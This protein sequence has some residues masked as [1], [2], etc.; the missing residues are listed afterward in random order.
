MRTIKEVL[1]DAQTIALSGHF[2]PDG[3]CTGSTMGLYHY[4]R[5]VYP[6]CQVDVFLEKIPPYFSIIDELEVIQH[7]DNQQIYDVFIGL[8]CDH[9]RLGFSS[10]IYDRAKRRVCIDH[11]ITNQSNADEV[12]L[13]AAASSTCEVVYRLLDYNVLPLKSAKALYMGIIHDTGVFRYP[14]TSP[15]TMEIAA[16]LMRKGIDSSDIIRTTFYEKTYAQNQVLG[17]A[18]FESML[19]LNKRCIAGVITQRDM[20]IF[21]LEKSDL[22]GIVSQMLLTK[23]VEVAIFL[24]EIALNQYKV[25]LRSVSKVDVSLV[26]G[27][28]GGGGHIRAAGVT[29]SGNRYDVINN[30]TAQIELQLER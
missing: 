22:E 20:H 24:H 21:G 14:N 30:L 27:Y 18:L 4:I 3:D 1:Q 16:Q 8:D 25:S 9:N 19:I 10:A 12:I 17:L 26:A 5:E 6:D 13:D 28:F 15:E 11:H 29:M 23:G 2:S 7:V